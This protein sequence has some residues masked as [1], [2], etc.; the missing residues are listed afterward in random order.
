MHM[1][2]D[3]TGAPL[4]NGEK[5]WSTTL[6]AAV[7]ALYMLKRPKTR[8]KIP[9]YIGPITMPPTITGMCMMVMDTMPGRMIKP[10][11]VNERMS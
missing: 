9:P 4:K 2:I 10:S 6:V 8:P 5:A 11:G 7:V 3:W 1:I